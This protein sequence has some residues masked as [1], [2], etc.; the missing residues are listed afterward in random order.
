MDTSVINY[1]AF[2]SIVSSSGIITIVRVIFDGYLRKKVVSLVFRYLD[3]LLV[4][5]SKRRR[6]KFRKVLLNKSILNLSPKKK[7][8]IRYGTFLYLEL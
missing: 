2:F 3:C 6:R 4:R 1:L 7:F 5:E 8:M